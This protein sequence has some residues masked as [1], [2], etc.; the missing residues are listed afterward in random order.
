MGYYLGPARWW[1]GTCCTRG[2]SVTQQQV[3]PDFCYHGQCEVHHSFLNQPSYYL[4]LHFPFPSPQSFIHFLFTSSSE[5]SS[6]SS[7]SSSLASSSSSSS[8]PASS[9]LDS[10]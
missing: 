3:S 5:A 10:S 8:S 9:S 2:S 6:S 1:C 7:S 4:S